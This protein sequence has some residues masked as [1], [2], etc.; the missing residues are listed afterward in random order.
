MMG[1]TDETSSLDANNQSV[2]KNNKERAF[3]FATTLVGTKCGSCGENLPESACDIIFCL[4]CKRG[5]HGAPMGCSTINEWRKLS[6]SNKLNHRCKSCRA[7]A[8][9]PPTQP[10]DGCEGDNER[11]SFPPAGDASK[12][13]T[14]AASLISGTAPATSGDLIQ[15]FAALLDQKLSPI[16]SSV[17]DL[18]ADLKNVSDA[19]AKSEE[20]FDTLQSRVAVLESGAE[21][22]DSRILALEAENDGLKKKIESAENYSRLNNVVIS[23]LPV[24]K[25]EDPVHVAIKAADIVGIKL[26]REDIVDCHRLPSRGDSKPFIVKFVS[27]LTARAV[28]SAYKSTRPKADKVGGDPSVSLFADR[29]YAPKT[30]FLLRSARTLR[31]FGYAAPWVK[32]GSVFVRANVRGAVDIE[33]VSEQDVERLRAGAA[34]N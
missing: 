17:S 7:Q 13:V 19:L 9:L 16:V 31:K 20:R 6:G 5:F 1:S 12:V 27:R 10:T 26:K 4:G 22:V 32:G 25:D 23:G 14:S 11:S 8:S 24:W 2:R 29:H 3:E 15:Q 34:R 28:I 33:I 30:S 21:S 18:K